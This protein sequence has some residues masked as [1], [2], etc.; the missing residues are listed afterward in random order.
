MRLDG[1]CK[2]AKLRRGCA[3][4]MELWSSARNR[5]VS[6]WREEELNIYHLQSITTGSKEFQLHKNL[7]TRPH[8]PFAACHWRMIKTSA[9]FQVN[10]SNS[11]SKISPPQHLPCKVTLTMS[12]D[13][14]GVTKRS[15]KLLLLR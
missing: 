6:T 11:H 1:V 13:H 14:A 2:G 10:E 8:V 9:M 7:Y 12:E 3:R 4:G 15:R 5:E